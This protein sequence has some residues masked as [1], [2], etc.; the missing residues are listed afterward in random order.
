M[1]RWAEDARGRLAASA[2][3]LFAE[4]GFAATTVDEVAAAAGVTQRTFFRH[5]RDKEEVL[6]AD[7]DRLLQVLL[8]GVGRAGGEDPEDDL[9]HA[10]E[11]ISVELEPRREQLRRRAAVISTDVSLTGR[12]LAKQAGWTAA[13]ARAL[14][15]RGYPGTQADLMAQVGFAVFR[16]AMDRWLAQDDGPSL[17]A[18]VEQCRADAGVAFG[19]R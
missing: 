16:H 9:R 12:E 13:V 19:S 17:T 2:L 15:E 11:S 10:L 4:R 7:D 5:F 3:E 8:D 6:F 14:R 18:H 1:A